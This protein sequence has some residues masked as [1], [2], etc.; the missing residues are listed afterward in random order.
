MN[1]SPKEILDTMLGFLGFVC[2]IKEMQV[3]QGTVLQIYTSEHDRLIGHH[4]ETLDDIQ[5]LLNR[6]VQA[7]DKEAPKVY[8]D[9]EHYREM[10]DDRVAQQARQAAEI[11]RETGLPQHLEPMNS[12]DR[13]IVH[14]LFKDD[15]EIVSFSP[16]DD[17]R[18]KK[19]TLK[20][21]ESAGAESP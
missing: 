9:I 11:V 17:A 1:Q 5:F 19:I 12:Y 6:V 14:N 2:E 8:V 16:A 20:K 18:I 21:S 13:R 10:R 4:G 7:Q 3:G 15:P